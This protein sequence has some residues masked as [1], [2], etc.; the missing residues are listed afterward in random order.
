MT[1]QPK[2]RVDVQVR[3]NY[4]VIA[5]GSE[6]VNSL[7][8]TMWKELIAAL[9]Q[10]ENDPKIRGI[11]FHSALTKNIFTAGNDL[12][13]LYAPLTSEEKYVQFWKAQ[14]IFLGRLFNTP[15]VVISAIKGACPAAGTGIAICSDIR[16]A[17]ADAW[18]SLNEVAIGLS[19][20]G[21]WIK[22]MAFLIGQG[23][24][25]KLCQYAKTVKAEE[26]K[27]IDLI[28]EIVADVSALLPAAEIAMKAV[29]RLSDQGRVI[30]KSLSRKAL[31]DEWTDDS[32]IAEEA[33]VAWKVLSSESTVK[34][35]GETLARLSGKP[36][37]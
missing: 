21:Q 26:A 2:K 31:S 27:Q 36:K 3:S 10:C 11:I 4:A 29:L 19:V 22:A 12:K 8:V 9:D 34:A 6:P 28:D 13:E 20:P 17:T 35:L 32:R 24:A 1:T 5:L 14:N 7:G 30:T 33:K 25:D 18:L 16:I 15:L 23:K 37:L